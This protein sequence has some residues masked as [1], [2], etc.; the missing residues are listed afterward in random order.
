MSVDKSASSLKENEETRLVGIG[1]VEARLFLLSVQLNDS[2]QKRLHRRSLKQLDVGLQVALNVLKSEYYGAPTSRQEDFLPLLTYFETTVA[3]CERLVERLNR[4]QAVLAVAFLLYDVEIIK[5]CQEEVKQKGTELRARITRLKEHWPDHAFSSQS[6]LS[7]T[8]EERSPSETTYT[9]PFHTPEP[10]SSQTP[11]TVTSLH[12]ASNASIQNS[13][14]N[15]AAN[16]INRMTFHYPP[17]VNNGGSIVLNYNVYGTGYVNT[18]A[19]S[20]ILTM[21]LKAP[22]WNDL[23]V[24]TCIFSTFVH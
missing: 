6:R 19:I 1:N 17:I 13:E 22:I 15:N 11:T 9:N 10:P 2:R 16:N 18:I 7:L 24:F 21:A 14:F 12:S 23:Y 8:A 3:R 5:R 20:T 4:R